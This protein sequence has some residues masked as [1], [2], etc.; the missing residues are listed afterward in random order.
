VNGHRA[1]FFLCFSP[2]PFPAWS[3]R[4]CGGWG[5]WRLPDLVVGICVSGVDVAD[6]VAALVSA[7]G[8]LDPEP[9]AAASLMVGGGVPSLL[10]PPAEVS[11]G[12]ASGG[13]L[14]SPSVTVVVVVGG[15]VPPLRSPPAPAHVSAADSP[16]EARHVRAASQRPLLKPGK[17]SG[18]GMFSSASSCEGASFSNCSSD[19]CSRSQ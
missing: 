3:S 15:G 18:Y 13:D 8:L 7:T 5:S 16:S 9:S 17:V 12:A 14:G 10:P 1:H 2:F 6:C 19:V 11:R 4:R